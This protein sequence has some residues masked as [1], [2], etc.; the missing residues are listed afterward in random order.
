MLI[1][2]G[3]KENWGCDKR[4]PGGGGVDGGCVPGV[5][6]KTK[7]Q[8]C[9]EPWRW[10]AGFR[11]WRLCEEEWEQSQGIPAGSCGIFFS[12]GI[13]ISETSRFCFLDLHF[14]YHETLWVPSCGPTRPHGNHP[15]HR[16]FDLP[17]SAVSPG[18]SWC[19]AK[20]VWSAL[21]T[22]HFLN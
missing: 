14:C 6:R 12:E 19:I 21:E 18:C 3:S 4:R 13:Q 9:K 15:K 5:W 8:A 16:R 1:S 20:G 10:A 11:K 2:G 17:G 7:P 22:S